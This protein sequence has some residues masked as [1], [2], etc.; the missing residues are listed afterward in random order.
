[1]PNHVTPPLLENL[2][3]LHI[4]KNGGNTLH[5][6]LKRI[7]QEDTIFDIEVINNTRLNTQE[8]IDLSQKERAKIKILKGHML[9][10]LHTHLE[11]PSKYITFLRKPEDRIV[12]FYKYV[13]SQ[14]QHYAYKTI[15]EQSFNEFVATS[16]YGEVHNAQ[17][18]WISGLEHETP[19]NMLE[20]ALENIDTHFAFVGLLEAYNTSLLLLS[21]LYGWGIPYYK[22]GNRGVQKQLTVDPQTRDLIIQ[23]NQADQ[24]LYD[25]IQERFKEQSKSLGIRAGLRH[26]Q[27][28]IANYLHAN[29]R[30]Q[31]I[32][33]KINK[34]LPSY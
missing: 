15:K 20:K 10:G 23:Y 25:S 8:F 17:V 1:M 11:G 14:P 7:Y 2:I 22:Y 30:V 28:D 9:Y 16:S 4:P 5:S 32:Q 21:K 24:E 27:L 26:K 29:Q 18:R 31:R 6:I 33:I 34:M 12:S 3:F 13:L 19:A